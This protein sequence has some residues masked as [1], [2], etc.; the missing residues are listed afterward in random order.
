[1]KTNPWQR[2]ANLKQAF[3]LKPTQG[4]VL[5]F[6]VGRGISLRILR[7][8]TTQQI[9]GFDSFAGLPEEWVMS[10][11]YIVEAGDFR[12]D[13]PQQFENV[14]FHKG[15]FADTIPVWKETYPAKIS[16]M[17]I[18]SDLYSSANTVLTELNERIVPGTIIVFDDMYG[19]ER[20]QNWEQGE[21]KAFNEWKE[22]YGRKVQ[23]INRTEDG[24]ASYRIL[25]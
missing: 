24:E 1:M 2:I 5:E 6:G 15:W 18:D 20:Y 22:N 3:N 10:D 21:Y 19:T 14:L 12:Y 8:M 13:K 23:E 7:M 17:H 25:S 16:F 4:Y 11:D 9:H